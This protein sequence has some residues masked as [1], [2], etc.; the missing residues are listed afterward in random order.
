MSTVINFCALIHLTLSACPRSFNDVPAPSPAKAAYDSLKLDI[1]GIADCFPSLGSCPQKPADEGYHQGYVGDKN[2]IKIPHSAFVDGSYTN[3]AKY[4]LEPNEYYHFAVSLFD[5]YTMRTFDI[6]EATKDK[7][8]T[9]VFTEQEWTDCITKSTNEGG[10]GSQFKYAGHFLTGPDGKITEWNNHSGHFKPDWVDRK[11]K[12]K[13]GE[14]FEKFWGWTDGEDYYAHQDA[15]PAPPSR[16]IPT[17]VASEESVLVIFAA[18][19]LVLAC[20]LCLVLHTMAVWIMGFGCGWMARKE[21]LY[22]DFCV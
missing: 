2:L 17:T 19:M 6:N 16:L 13:N 22:G 3:E 8:H 21:I 9:S 18:F 4:G 5:P 12:K 20:C 14:I 1:N 11:T 10:D 7:G 15:F